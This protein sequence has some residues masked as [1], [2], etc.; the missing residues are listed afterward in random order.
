M[1]HPRKKIH[2]SR[3]QKQVP[4]RHNLLDLVSLLTKSSWHLETN[5]HET[6]FIALVDIHLI[7][8]EVGSGQT[9]MINLLLKSD[10]LPVCEKGCTKVYC[11]LKTGETRRATIYSRNSKTKE[12]TIKNLD[13]RKDTDKDEMRQFIVSGDELNVHERVVIEFPFEFLEVS[14][15][16]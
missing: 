1:I 6:N 9:S 10:L 8:G 16:L 15:S 12:A 5:D 14:M 2:A 3:I 13:L 11:Q 4:L 7:L